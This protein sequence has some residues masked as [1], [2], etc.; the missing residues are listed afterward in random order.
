LPGGLSIV[1]APASSRA[2]SGALIGLIAFVSWG[3]VPLYW[4]L[5]D[6]VSADRIVAHRAIWSLVFVAFVVILSAGKRASVRDAL[7]RP[8]SLAFGALAGW[9]I[10]INWLIYIFAVI[11]GHVIEASLGYFLSPLVTVALGAFV[12]GERLPTLRWVAVLLAAA[13]VLLKVILH[14]TV[15]WI[16]ISLC[17]TWGCYALVK[18]LAGLDSMSGLFVEGVA[19][20]PPALLYLIFAPGIGAG[21]GFVAG[22]PR[23]P[24]L[25]M[26]GGVITAVPLLCYA[27]ATRRLTLATLGLMQYIT[28]TMTFLL[29]VFL[30]R[31][32][33]ERTDLITFGCIWAGLVLYSA[34][35]TEA[36]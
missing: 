32:P 34:S 27:H 2:T 15:P 25:L 3:L 35:S 6:D 12:L 21:P 33:F 4:K 20:L 16:A 31:E 8:R 24:L 26:G 11:R 36:R 23:V 10:G 30:Y 14:G 1:H 19:I 7:K 18:K 17:S 13:G 22:W 29:G 9:L 28:P 5:I